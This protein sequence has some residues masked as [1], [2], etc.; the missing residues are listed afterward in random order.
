MRRVGLALAALALA[1]TGCTTAII[2]AYQT[3]SDER[4][5]Q[6]QHDDARIRLKH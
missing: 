4:T 3:L 6:E 2:V 5:V 1:Q